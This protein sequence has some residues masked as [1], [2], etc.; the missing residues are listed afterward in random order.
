MHKAYNASFVALFR[1]LGAGAL[2][3]RLYSYT[4]WMGRIL[5]LDVGEKRTG[6]A[7]SDET[8]MIAQSLPTIQHK[9]EKR[10]VDE[11]ERLIAEYEVD[12]IVVG[13]PLSLSGKPSTRSELV[14]KF[15]A[16]LEKALGIPVELF[17]E[18][19]STTRANRILE[20]A[21]GGPRKRQKPPATGRSKSRKRAVDRIAAT[22]ILEDYLASK[23]SQR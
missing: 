8:R 7:V 21:Y 16:R 9:S 11:V 19:Y 13:L 17:D 2:L 12:A 6:V 18:R 5:C 23:E 4:S 3:D 20:Q 1:F 10:L 22:V 15:S 14:R